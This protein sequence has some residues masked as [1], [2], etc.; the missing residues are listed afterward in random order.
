VKTAW[1]VCF[2]ILGLGCDAGD[3]K[4]GR[5]MPEPSQCPLEASA[6]TAP[7]FARNAKDALALRKNLDALVMSMRNA[8][9][10]MEAA[11]TATFETLLQ[12]GAPNLAG[13]MDSTWQAI[14]DD[15]FAEFA[16]LTAVGAADLINSDNHW[17]P[18]EHGGLFGQDA[19]G[20]NAGGIEVRQIVDKGLYSGGALYRYALALTENEI[21]S[22]TVDAL[23][24]A[25]GSNETLS[26]EGKTDSANY[27]FAMGFHGRITTALTDA[28]TFAADPRCDEERDE[29]LERFFRGWEQAM[30]SRTLFYAT[31]A[32]EGLTTAVNDDVRADALHEYSEGL[33]LTL[34]FYRRPEVKAGPLAGRGAVLTDDDVEQVLTLL[35]VDVR[36]LNRSRI[37]EFINDPQQL[38][39]ALTAA[40]ARL[41]AIF[42]WTEA[43]LARFRNPTQG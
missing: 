41:A 11:E 22:A 23:A 13:F 34:G 14:L 16:A 32:L 25:W 7:D 33:G 10:K 39:N 43:D 26:P 3:N 36:D 30:V 28:K 19:R 24:A 15:V 35:G 1:L 37:G 17:E 40:E 4:T 6:W 8:E 21:T 18:G 29:A 12:A 5:L 20:I 2:L 38:K 31:F 27:S 42:G 9:L